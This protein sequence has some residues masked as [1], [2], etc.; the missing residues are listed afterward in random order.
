M[1]KK[2]E[3][4]YDAVKFVSFVVHRR[5]S[6]LVRHA[7]AAQNSNRPLIRMLFEDNQQGRHRFC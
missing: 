7:A 3:E 6:G 1:A 5:R 2:L 4:R